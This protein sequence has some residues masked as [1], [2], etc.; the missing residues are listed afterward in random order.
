MI[1]ASFFKLATL[2]TG[3]PV[4]QN[5]S[6]VCSEIRNGND[7]DDDWIRVIKPEIV[8]HQKYRVA[9]NS[10]CLN[11]ILGSKV[12]STPFRPM[13]YRWVH[14]RGHKGNHL[15]LGLVSTSPR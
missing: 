7:K 14:E 12:K 3:K 9:T 1:S 15:A 6:L 8:T 10:T 4:N 13:N 5:Q 2:K 11:K